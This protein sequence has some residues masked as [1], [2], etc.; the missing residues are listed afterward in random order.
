YRQSLS[1]GKAEP[2][3]PEFGHAASPSLSYDGQWV[4]YAYTYE[5]KDGIA[6]VDSKG[7]LWPRKL[8]DSTDF[9]MQPVWHPDGRFL[10]YIAWNH[11]N[12]PWDG[13]EL[14]L[15]EMAQD[16]AGVPY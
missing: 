16:H 5:R 13:T 3:T 7:T 14:I 9:V 8:A 6:L 12:M 2:I 15:A 1:G 11:P 10:A 4:A